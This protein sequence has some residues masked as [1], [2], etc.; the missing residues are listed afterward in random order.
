MDLEYSVWIEG[1]QGKLEDLQEA[2]NPP[3]VEIADADRAARLRIDISSKVQSVVSRLDSVKAR[4]DALYNT[5]LTADQ[6]IKLQV[7]CKE[8]QADATENIMAMYTRLANLDSERY[9]ETQVTA[10]TTIANILKR[11]DGTRV[12]IEAYRV[13]PPEIEAR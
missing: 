13:T 1:I 2:E 10:A 4:A 9:E 3:I 5:E 6:V 12:L 11:V 8:V 7:M